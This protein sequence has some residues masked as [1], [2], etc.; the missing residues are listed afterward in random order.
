MHLSVGG[1]ATLTHSTSSRPLV[2]QIS[3]GRCAP[4]SCKRSH[5]QQHSRRTTLL[6]QAYADSANAMDGLDEADDFYSILGV[7]SV[8]P[9]SP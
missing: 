9:K 3:G 2:P 1:V 8:S 5:L 4:V 7:V 6:C